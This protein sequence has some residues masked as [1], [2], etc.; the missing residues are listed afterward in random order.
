[1]EKELLNRKEGQTGRGDGQSQYV[2]TWYWR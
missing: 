2:R 1:M